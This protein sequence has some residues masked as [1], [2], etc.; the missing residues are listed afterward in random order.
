VLTRWPHA[1][2]MD[3]GPAPVWESIA[4][5]SH[6]LS[7]AGPAPKRAG[8]WL[9]ISDNGNGG[10]GSGSIVITAAYAIWSMRAAAL[11]AN[12]LRD[13]LRMTSTGAPSSA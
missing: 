1:K 11:G 7:A 4:N 8:P 10:P 3:T 2:V 5:I 6:G 12:I 9:D 13:S